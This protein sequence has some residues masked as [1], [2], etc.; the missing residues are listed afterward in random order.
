MQIS[1]APSR[2][3]TNWVPEEISFEDLAERVA[4]PRITDET[5]QT[6]I[7]LDRESQTNI[8]DVGGFVMGSLKGGRRKGKN[9]ESR[10][11]IALDLDNLEG[12]HDLDVVL[13]GL[14]NLGHEYCLYS[15]HKS[16]P[17][18]PRIR[19]LFPLKREVDSEEYEF[20]TRQ[21]CAYLGMGFC[22]KTTAQP[23]RL[24]FWP[25]VSAD[26][27]ESF[28]YDSRLLCD[29]FGPID[30]DF[31]F[32]KYPN[33]RDRTI[34][35]TFPDEGSHIS[36][37]N[38]QLD[39]PRDKDGIIGAFCR[40]YTIPEVIDAYLSDVY[41]PTDDPT[42]YT[43]KPGSTSK[44]AVLYGSDEYHAD[45]F[46]YSFHNTD[47]AGGRTSN[48]FDLVRLHK[49]GDTKA[50]TRKMEKLA[51]EDERV[52]KIRAEELADEK[53][54][55]IETVK[56]DPN[57]KHTD[58][59]TVFGEIVA[60]LEKDER[61]PAKNA[62]TID[63]VLQIL[64]RDLF[65]ANTYY[66][67]SFA[68]K[69]VIQKNSMPWAGPK[70]ERNWK[71]SDDA[72]LK[73]YLEKVYGIR[74][75]EIILDALCIS[76]EERSIHPVKDYLESL[77]WDGT[78]RLDTL[79]IDYFGAEDNVYTRDVMRKS[80]VAAV[81]R[82][83]EPGAKYDTM[84]IFVGEQGVGKSTFIN[85]LGKQWYSDSVTDF[86]GKDSYELL[87]N[88]WLIEIPEL[89]GFSKYE[90]NQIK[91]FLSKQVDEYRAPYQRRKESHKRQCVFFGTTN[92][93]VFLRD[94]TGNRRFWPVQ[95]GVNEPT[96]NVFDDLVD[97]EIDQI[98]AE[99][100]FDYLVGEPLYL[101]GDSKTI[102][103]TEQAKRLEDDP[104]EGMIVAFLKHEI[105][106]D[107]ERWNIDQR[108]A[109]WANPDGFDDIET[110]KRQ[111]VCPAEIA[112]E[113]LNV[114]KDRMDKRLS[115]E[116]NDILRGLPGSIYMRHPERRYGDIYG[117]AR[118]FK[119]DPECL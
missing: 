76:F 111:Y 81:T 49:F 57:F 28:I 51:M 18:R 110:K 44:G 90:M 85:R 79:L 16:T 106:T 56:N 96:K 88:N 20:I 35:P 55:F 104:R 112:V 74:G 13:N 83:Y 115:R 4:T 70:E 67:D 103:E 11:G 27:K 33:W 66:Y 109:Y 119:I 94:K 15:T 7:E 78:P 65:F 59:R 92:D 105:P 41:E 118:G 8:K 69:I 98:W 24:M 10:S 86:V 5:Y 107:W 32:D 73:W 100:Y 42:R 31:Y 117:V 91:H 40:T 6:F 22:D 25:S 53:Q 37:P 2:T 71:D 89:N 36:D 108:R 54:N 47:P 9:V 75:K 77:E 1:I 19:I 80:L 93:E 23:V 39:D 58:W 46:L 26:M 68:D 62:S 101:T 102:S 97:S 114:P 116:I 95:L 87:Q 60:S 3:A 43:Y 99:A 38:A 30:P 113:V 14:E 17:K 45:V 82:I 63:N 64:R 12:Q 34:W 61:N 72:G 52:R 29:G 48:A 21:V 50:S 84:P